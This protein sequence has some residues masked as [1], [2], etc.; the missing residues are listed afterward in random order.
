MTI[1]D[2]LA[3]LPPELHS[4]YRAFVDDY[5]AACR[6]ASNRVFVNHA[7]FVA[8]LKSGLWRKLIP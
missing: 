1:D 5:Q 8:L 6:A 7:V 3:Q 4:T 2:A